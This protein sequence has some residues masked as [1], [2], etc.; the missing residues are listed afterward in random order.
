V[1]DVLEVALGGMPL[2]TTV[3]G[4]ERYS[5]TLRYSRDFRENLG[6][7]RDIIVPTPTGAQVPLGQLAKIETVRAP[8][9][10]K[11]EGAVPNAWIYVDV[12]GTDIGSYVEAARRAVEQAVARGSI[13]MPSG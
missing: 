1:Q 13:R 5:V 2:T 6:V 4:L 9:G 8:M 10:I 7:L 11:S 12:K 3:E